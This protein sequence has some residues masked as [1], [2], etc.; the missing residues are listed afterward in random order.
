M[1]DDPAVRLLDRSTW[2]RG[3]AWLSGGNLVGLIATLLAGIALARALGPRDFGLYSVIAVAIGTAVTVVSY[4]LDMHLVTELH[5]DPGDTEVFQRALLA[6]TMLAVAVCGAGLSAL[7]LFTH[8]SKVLVIL[9][10]TEVA[11][12]PMLLSR[13]VLQV[14]ARQRVL[15]AASICNRV[16]WLSL[17]GA[18][19]LVGPASPLVFVLAARIVAAGAEIAVLASASG[20]VLPGRWP[21]IRRWPRSEFAVLRAATPL[22]LAGLA[23]LVYNRSDQFLLAWLR[24]TSETGLY[25]AG[26]RVADLLLFLGPIVQNVTLPGLVHLARRRDTSAIERAASDA[27]LLSVT[28]AGLAAAVLLAT[29]GQIASVVFGSAYRAVGPLAVVLA[30]GAWVALLGTVVSSVAL[31]MGERRTM[32]VATVCGLATNV[33]LNLLLLGRYGALAAAWTSVAAYSIASLLPAARPTLRGPVRAL[34][35]TAS[36]SAIGMI[37]GWAL[38]T[39]VP[40]QIGAAAAAGV[41][42]V[43]VVGALRWPDVKR[44]FRAASKWHARRRNP[45]TTMGVR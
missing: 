45:L 34:L 12:S 1:A 31:A 24:G 5:S 33:V 6:S 43:A 40:S 14:R 17:V 22:A 42:Y 19:V 20:A 38:G 8:S 25:A 18:I 2:L 26:V 23:G 13:A 16:V 10:M 27:V 41:A 3:S 28:P 29:D 15:A 11:L 7:L 36:S 37:T 4:R 39:Q 30:L 44:L 21:S 35:L 32:L 9:A